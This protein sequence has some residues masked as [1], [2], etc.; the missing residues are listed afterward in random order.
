MLLPP[1]GSKSVD[2]R[3]VSPSVVDAAGF[4]PTMLVVLALLGLLG[5]VWIGLG[6]AGAGET[7]DR[8]LGLLDPP[9]SDERDE[10]RKEDAA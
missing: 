5:V 3:T 8:G 2:E 7:V 6:V 1:S 4:P 10:D 9:E